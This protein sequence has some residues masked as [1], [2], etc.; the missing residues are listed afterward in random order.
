MKT[1]TAS[2]LLEIE[3]LVAAYCLATDNKD[4]D[5]L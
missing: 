1:L 3:N 5:G 4:V 2:D